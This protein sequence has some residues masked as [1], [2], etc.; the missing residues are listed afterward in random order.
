[1]NFG[2][3]MTGGLAYVLRREV[4]QVLNLEFV[5]AHELEDEEERQLRVLLEAHVAHTGSPVAFRLL[6][7]KTCL[8]FLRVQPVHFQGTLETAWR[9]FPAQPVN[10]LPAAPADLLAASKGPVPHY[11]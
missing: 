1:L 11:A 3:G 8:P 9:A 7:Q 2:S 6:L 10:P 5:Q 4:D